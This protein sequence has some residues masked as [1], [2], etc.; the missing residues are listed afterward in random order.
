[1]SRGE[2]CSPSSD[3]VP[4][5]ETFL[6]SANVIISALLNIDWEEVVHTDSKLDLAFA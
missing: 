2:E 3:F 6:P 4:S 5:M 1:M